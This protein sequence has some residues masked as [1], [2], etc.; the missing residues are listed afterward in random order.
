MK[1]CIISK[2]SFSSIP[3]IDTYIFLDSH[4]IALFEEEQ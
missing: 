3:F 1:V 2:Q 4:R